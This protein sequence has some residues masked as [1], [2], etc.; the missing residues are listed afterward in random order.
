MRILW[1]GVNAG[2]VPAFSAEVGLANGL[3]LLGDEV[4]RVSCQG[5]FSRYCPVIRVEQLTVSASPRERTGV[6][7]RCQ[8]IGESADSH[9]AYDSIA[10][11]SFVTSED[12]A[13]ARDLV[14]ALNHRTWRDFEF[15]DVEVG[16]YASYLTMLHHKVPDV[17]ATDESWQ[18]YLVDVENCIKV[19]LA[20]PRLLDAV[21]PSH[22]L[23]YNPLYPTNR[24]MW[25]MA[26]RRGVTNISMSLG[27]YVP[28]R[29][30]TV[31]LYPHFSSSQTVTDSTTVTRSLDVSCS[32]AEVHATAR[33]LRGLI[34][35]NDPW[36]YSTAPS[37]A[38]AQEIKSILGVR[39]SAPVV[40]A[41]VASPDETRASALVGA[42]FDRIPGQELS[43]VAEFV[44]VAIELGRRNPNLDVVIR[45]HPRLAPNKREQ[46]E[47]PDL[48]PIH[49]LLQERPSNVLVNAPSDGVGL[50]DAVRITDVGLNQSSSAGLELMVFGRPVV[51]YDPPRM[52]AYPTWLGLQVDRGNVSRLDEAIAEALSGSSP[53]DF[54]HLA[55][56][57]YAVT[58]L[59]CLVH[60]DSL[61]PAGPTSETATQSVPAKSGSLRGLLPKGLRRVIARRIS[62]QKERQLVRPVATVEPWVVEAR[63]RILSLGQG[64]IWNPQARVRGESLD[65][66]GP[67]IDA[68][69]RGIKLD[70]GWIPVEEP[71]GPTQAGS[72]H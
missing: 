57:W 65:D 3:A 9:A 45:L 4:V 41:L 32:S 51:H 26:A 24:I 72:Q 42:E 19:A 43:D 12:R 16:R 37:A 35:G 30:G 5:M 15:S 23:V 47:S 64:P 60:K 2:L 63:E 18:E 61:E 17:T 66:D 22:L 39:P 52:N 44:E 13:I 11:D 50:Y 48:G 55:F 68:V 53:E 62:Y 31:A 21:N 58:L 14:A 56:R 1:F 40:L 70:L 46:I 28:N 38:S 7:R 20:A 29:Q 67:A 71:G 33:H 34:A 69:L 54:S 49:R 59:R 6:C 8:G 36:V 25:E 27:G 10:L